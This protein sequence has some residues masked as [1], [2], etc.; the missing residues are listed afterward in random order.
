MKLSVT[1]GR[2]PTI[3]GG[4]GF[5]NNDACLYPVMEPEHFNQVICKVYRELSPGFMRT[6]AGYDDWTKEAMDWF[7]EYYEKMQKWTDTPIYLAAAMAKFHFSEEERTRYCERV[8]DNLCYLKKEKGVD[9]LR[10][11]CFSN[12]LSCGQHGVL[13]E[14]LPLHKNYHEKLYRAFQNRDL[15]VGLLSTDATGYNQWKSI[16]WAIE[17]MRDITE[18]FCVHIYERNYDIYDLGFYEFFR[19][20]CLEYVEKS[21]RCGGKRLI[22]G[23]VGITGKANQLGFAKGT[24]I[25]TSSYFENGQTAD[26]A[27]MMAE[28]VF[29]AINAG[30]FALVYWSFTDY[31]DPYSCAHGESGYAAKWGK[32]EKFISGTTDSKY[33]KWGL[34]RWED[35]G[36]YSAR[37]H[38]WCLGWIA[39]L[40]KRN[41]KILDIACED[42][43]LRSAAILNRDG[44]VSLGVVN[45]NQTETPITLDS[46]L[47]RKPIRVY[48]YDP[49]NVPMNPFLDLQGWS[50]VVN[51]GEEFTL[52]PTSVTFFTTDYQEK[53]APVELSSVWE[54]GV[55]TWEVCQD[56][57]HCYY[58]VFRGETADFVSAPENQ[59]AS[60]VAESL[61][62]EEGFY[63]VLSVDR[64]G[65]CYGNEKDRRQV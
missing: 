17:N 49:K 59:V 32:V 42:P 45:R 27:L 29:A 8:A 19:E 57:Q 60:T 37:E 63:K 13:H 5:H 36:D 52:K 43:L 15:D 41:S 10:Y 23:E 16:D 39:K 48:E 58:R 62:A 64:S 1:R 38:Y 2:Y 40:F 47:F 44:S 30:V 4:F 53:A 7:A 18:D 3:F 26:A 25:D 61:P 56:P 54:N 55:L 33:N 35:N 28:M 65:N 34:M 46:T 20:K 22:L 6:F 24:I 14:N 12:E 11:Y 51:P 21:I 50:C 9:H 31:P